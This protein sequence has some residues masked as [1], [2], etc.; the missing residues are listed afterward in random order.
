MEIILTNGFQTPYL[1][2]PYKNNGHCIP[3]NN[4]KNKD[5]FIC[6]C[7]N[8]YAGLYCERKSSLINITFKI[9]FIPSIIFAHFITASDD[10]KHERITTFRKSSIRSTFNYIIYYKTI[11]YFIY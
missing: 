8:D 2:T 3:I 10:K 11:S 1:V 6:L 9:D 5:G 4:H 7:E